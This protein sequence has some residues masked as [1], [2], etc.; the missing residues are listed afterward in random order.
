[1][2]GGT[3]TGPRWRGRVVRSRTE[4]RSARSEAPSPWSP[5]LLADLH[6]RVM[7]ESVTGGAATRKAAAGP[8]RS[9]PGQGAPPV[10]ALVH[11]VGVDRDVPAEG[12]LRRP[13]AAR[14]RVRSPVLESRSAW[15]YPMAAGSSRRPGTAPSVVA[16]TTRPGP[17]TGAG[18]EDHHGPTGA[19]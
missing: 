13:A 18:R 8:K 1:M 7:S 3:S 17:V 5:F 12:A 15:A 11:E 16:S 19:S 10:K 2:T 6:E 9:P 14:A 4:C